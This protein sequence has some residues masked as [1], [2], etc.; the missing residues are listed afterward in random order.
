MKIEQL[1]TS[2]ISPDKKLVEVNKTLESTDTDFSEILMKSLQG[3][4]DD[5]IYS[6]QMDN[7]LA[8]GEID[9]VHDVTIAALKA[10]LSLSMAVEVTNKVLAA[11]NEIMR[12]QF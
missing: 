10:D 6:E 3:V 9:D 7:L 12:I 4:S 1:A 8:L 2:I 5:Q 11:Y